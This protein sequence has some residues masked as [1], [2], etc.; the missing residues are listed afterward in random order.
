M[1]RER[2]FAMIKPD[3]VQDRHCGNIISLIEENGFDILRMQKVTLSKE[4]AERFYAVHNHRPFFSELVAFVISG[5][6]VIMALEKDNAVNSWRKL[7]GATDPAQAEL[8][9]IRALFGAN[10]GKNATHGSDA[11][12]TACEELGLFFPDLA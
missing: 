6:V 9:T 4:K 7:M 8:G 5:P 10:I 3:A 1:T 12:E 2:T 11:P